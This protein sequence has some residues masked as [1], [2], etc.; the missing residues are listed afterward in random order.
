[1]TAS[2]I[3]DTAGGGVEELKRAV[4]MRA[5]PVGDGAAREAWSDPCRSRVRRVNR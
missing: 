5:G 3:R 4:Q 1:M 2:R